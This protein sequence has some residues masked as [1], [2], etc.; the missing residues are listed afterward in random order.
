MDNEHYVYVHRRMT[1]GVVFYVGKGRGRRA[2]SSSG[3]NN[4]WKNVAAK[5]G[6]GVKIAKAEMPEPCALSFERCL[7]A[8]IGR[9][10][11]TNLVDGGGGITG[12]KHSDEAKAKIGRHWKGREFTPKMRE[13]LAEY[14]KN[15]IISDAHRANISAAKKGKK[16]GPKSAETRAKISA[17][18]MGMKH[19]EETRRKMSASSPRLRGVNS[20]SHDKTVREFFHPEHG[21]VVCTQLELRE[22]FGL[23]SSCLS[24]VI[25]GKQKSVKGWRIK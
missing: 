20:N 16:T 17:A 8:A 18:H 2:W 15:R 12:W 1:D 22:R 7:I 13:A 6:F 4:W 19:S 10:N 21:T 9:D 3:R 25:H 23:S 11:L 5:H 24:A 14:N